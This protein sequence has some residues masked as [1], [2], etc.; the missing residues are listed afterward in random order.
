MF[1]VK[2]VGETVAVGWEE[3]GEGLL[4]VGHGKMDNDDDM[5]DGRALTGDEVSSGGSTSSS[6]D[7]L[8]PLRKGGERGGVPTWMPSP[9][10]ED[11]L[12]LAIELAV[13]FM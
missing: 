7:N 4:D 5:E 1:W 13:G 9:I 6:P 12:P 2:G 8:L 3:V 10:E 11:R